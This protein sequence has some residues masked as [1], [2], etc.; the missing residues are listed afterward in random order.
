MH[1]VQVES[2][3]SKCRPERQRL[4]VEAGP[5]DRDRGGP[6]PLGRQ[7]PAEVGRLDGR[8]P[9]HGARVE[10]DVEARAEAD[11]DDLAREPGAHPLAQR[12]RRLHPARDVDDPRQDLVA[13][14]AHRATVSP[15]GP[16][17]APATCASRLHR[18]R[19]LG[20]SIASRG[21]GR[22]GTLGTGRR[23]RPRQRSSMK[24]ATT[25]TP[26]GT[27]AGSMSA[28]RKNTALADAKRV[29]STAAVS[30]RAWPASA[31]PS[32]AASTRSG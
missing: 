1:I 31:V 5:L 28:N 16:A 6:H 17:V 22:R 32:T 13:V 30:C 21:A 3:A 10:G 25:A 12:G 18:L 24:S 15:I 2:A 7:L 14:D 27:V 29:T 19:S 9:R 20:E 11:L 4:P 8:D 26:S 23:A